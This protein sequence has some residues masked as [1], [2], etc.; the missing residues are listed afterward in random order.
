[1]T[2][3][4]IYKKRREELAKRISNGVAIICNAPVHERTP[5]V[6]YPHRV[7]SNFWYLT[8]FGDNELEAAS[9]L[10]IVAEDG[11]AKSI[12]FCASEMDE[13]QRVWTGDTVGPERA[14]IEFGFNE[15]YPVDNLFVFWQKIGNHIFSGGPVYTLTAKNPAY[16]PAWLETKCLQSILSEMRVIKDQEE[17]KL[18][19]E[20]SI[21]TAEAQI[22]AMKFCRTTMRESRVDNAVS[23]VFS[24]YHCEKSFPN[25]VASGKHA[26][27]LHYGS[28]NDVYDQH[29]DLLLVDIGAELKKYAGDISRTFPVSGKFS[30]VQRELYKIVLEAQKAAVKKVRKGNRFDAPH[31]T[32]VRIIVQGLVRL[33]LLHGEVNELIKSK[34]YLRF[35]PHGTSHFVGLDVHDV[36]ERKEADGKTFRKLEPGMVLTVEPGIYI[37]PD[38]ETVPEKYRG[39]G[40]RIE[41]DV[42][43]T[44]GDPEVFSKDSPKEIDEIETLMCS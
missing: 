4:S 27:T 34:A 35:F 33:N 32:A 38:D 26:C 39:L 2:E 31:K 21:I 37:Q 40:I 12:L 17:I 19:R 30:E 41:D 15:A 29:G 3:K 11:K 16:I 13:K 9:V 7:D 36:G 18:L 20:A 22:E 23:T 8:G 5:T 14:K 1:M 6:N 10:V 25:V 43:V 44:E 42:L 24:L 28:N